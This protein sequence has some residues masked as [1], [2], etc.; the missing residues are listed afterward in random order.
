MVSPLETQPGHHTEGANLAS[1]PGGGA[2]KGCVHFP[3]LRGGWDGLLGHGA[4]WSAAEIPGSHPCAG[5]GTEGR[6]A[7]WGFQVRKRALW[8]H[9]CN[10]LEAEHTQGRKHA[11]GMEW[12]T[13]DP[14]SK[15]TGCGSPLFHC[16][17]RATSL[18][19]VQWHEGHKGSEWVQP[20][21]PARD[22]L[23]TGDWQ[24]KQHWGL[25]GF[26]VV[27]SLRPEQSLAFL[28]GVDTNI[29]TA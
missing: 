27:P 14:P 5:G 20:Y 8:P 6:A 26:W 10:Q 1:C 2:D 15:K 12:L 3:Q 23:F 28:T 19:D 18:M 22:S 17:H 13:R 24:E 11:A 25:Q 16:H 7:N 9:C 21:L 4:G 29:T